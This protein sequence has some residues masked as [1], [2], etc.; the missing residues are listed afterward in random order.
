MSGETQHL[1]LGAFLWPTGHHIAAWRH[2][3]VPAD[4]GVNF[5]HFAEVARIAERGLFDMLFLADQAAIFNDTADNLSR[6]S[7]MVRI[8]PYTLL[9]A[10]ATMTSHIGLVCTA[11]TTYDEPYHIARRFASLDLVSGGRSGW[12]VVTS[13]NPA[14]AFN[15][16]REAHVEH[17]ERY[18][19]AWEFVDVVQGLWDSWD[20][21]AFM[22]NK[23][24]GRYL[25]PE[26][27]HVLEHKGKYFSVRG[28]LNVSRSP[29]GQ[30]VIVQAGSSDVGRDLAAGVAEVVFTAHQT[31]ADA[32]AFHEDIKQRAV[33]HGR[34]P[35]H[36][37]VMPGVFPIVGRTEAEARDKYEEL[38]SLIDPKI[39]LA[40]LSTFIK[41]DLSSYPFDGPV[42][43]L[44]EAVKVSS[45]PAM[46]LKLARKENLTVRQLAMRIAG[47]RGHW[48]LVGSPSRIA[49]QLEEWFVK[50]GADGFNV[51]PPTFPGSLDDFVALVI[52]EL[53]RRG[54]FRRQYDGHTLRANL[55]LPHPQSRFRK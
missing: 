51:M 9:A 6:N 42:P 50:G 26:K 12:N 27:M 15:F 22:R 30:P 14:E 21:D 7:Y 3:T 5:N 31:L 46:L 34:N 8:E 2:P 11:T 48:H 4:A 49:D 39:A 1:K 28:P 55:G 41:F 23:A 19:R 13:A 36:V 25:D 38:Q 37:K 54:L 16:N 33:R 43:D 45:R 35:D 53:Q 32:Q 17:D 47:S 29:Q 44:P 20:D 24:T 52:P 18:R 40:Q 10:L